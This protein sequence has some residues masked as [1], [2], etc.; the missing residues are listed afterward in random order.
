MATSTRLRLFHV[1]LPS[2]LL[3]FGQYGR[4]WVECVLATYGFAHVYDENQNILW[5]F[6]KRVN[7]LKYKFCFI[8][9]TIITRNE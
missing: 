5:L 6:L 4:K 1:A 3:Q 7:F 9:Y 2:A 8:I